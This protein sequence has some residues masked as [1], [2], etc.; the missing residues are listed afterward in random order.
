MSQGNL[1]P[2]GTNVLCALLEGKGISINKDAATAYGLSN[3]VA[4]HT[5]GTIENNTYLNLVSQSIRKA[6]EK[7][8]SDITLSTYNK[9]I[10]IGKESIPALGN[11]NPSTFPD[12]M[13]LLIESYTCGGGQSYYQLHYIPEH[14]TKGSERIVSVK[15]NG[16][17]VDPSNYQITGDTLRYTGKLLPGD[18]IGVFSVEGTSYGFVHVISN[19]AMREFKYGKKTLEDFCLSFTICQGFIS[20]SNSKINT[21]KNAMGFLDGTYSNMNDLITSDITGITLSTLHW[22]Q[23]LVKL[24]RAIDLSKLTT[25]GSPYNLLLTMKK[26]NSIINSVA[27]VLL[28]SGFNTSSLNELLDESREPTKLELKNL[29]TTFEQIKDDTLKDVLITLNV[30]TENIETLADLL[31]PKKLFPKSYASLTVPK[32]NTSSGPTNSKT[33]YLIYANGGVN[34]QLEQFNYGEELQGIVPRYVYKACGSL[35]TS[36][37]Q[38][39]HIQNM[40]IEK[41][42]QI[43]SNMET[44]SGLDNVNGGSAPTNSDALKKALQQVA[45]GTGENGTYVVTDFFGAMTGINYKLDKVKELISEL[46]TT[47]LKEIYQKL[48]EEVSE[49]LPSTEKIEQ[50]IWE[51]NNEIKNIKNRKP[52]VSNDLNTI[53]DSIGKQLLKEMTARDLAITQYTQGTV[54]DIYGFNDSINLWALET[55]PNM[56]AQVLEAI[57]DLNHIGGQSIIGMMRE[58]RNS[59]RLGLAGGT[60]DNKI[61]DVPPVTSVAEPTIPVGNGETLPKVTGETQTPGSF[62]G[63]PEIDLVPANLDIFNIS[64]TTKPSIIEPIKAVEQVIHCNC[65]CWDDLPN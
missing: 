17:T 18:K 26:N 49:S 14:L 65:D 42:S 3:T 56:S 22:G 51:A 4:Q 12:Y 61:P 10:A 57:S 24:G 5:R 59:K 13:P 38:V 60:T 15:V 23:D 53:W 34:S 20:Q 25:F 9:L 16:V 19:Q 2:L 52:I 47:E 55:E 32:F 33:Y 46:E 62:G 11:S 31:N 30:Q 50:Y 36:M 29:Y 39:K 37:L 21:L 63:S 35:R 28:T 27:Q 43:V 7:L 8:G 41:F 58:E 6:Y 48:L 1:T 64:T 44:T 54:T 40:E 45:L